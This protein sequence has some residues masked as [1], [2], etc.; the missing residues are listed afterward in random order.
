MSYDSDGYVEGQTYICSVGCGGI[1][2]ID[3]NGSGN[4]TCCDKPMAKVE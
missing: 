1:V 4:L 3:T 2:T